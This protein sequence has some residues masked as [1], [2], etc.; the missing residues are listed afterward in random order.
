MDSLKLQPGQRIRVN[1]TINGRDK[2]WTTRVEGTV[3]SC[4]AEPTGS[5]YAH[6]KND[7]LWLQ[8]IRLKKDDGEM[9]TLALDQN[10]LVT[11]LK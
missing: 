9:T 8:R 6:G 3:L 10:S 11:I 4:Q 1:Q 2:T 7:R 5:W